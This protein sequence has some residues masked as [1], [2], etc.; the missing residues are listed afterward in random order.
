MPQKLGCRPR[1]G[2][3]NVRIPV[4]LQGRQQV[5]PK[6]HV[7]G[8]QLV[9]VRQLIDSGAAEDEQVRDDPELGGEPQVRLGGDGHLVLDAGRGFQPLLQEGLDAGLQQAL[10][11]QAVELP[12]QIPQ[13]NRAVARRLVQDPQRLTLGARGNQQM[14]VQRAVGDQPLAAGGGPDDLFGEMVDQPGGPAIGRRK[15]PERRPGDQSQRQGRRRQAAE[16]VNS[17]FPAPF[18]GCGAIHREQ[19]PRRGQHAIQRGA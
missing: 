11:T 2:R 3:R 12:R 10:Q 13:V 15:I 8:P 16:A 17:P 14:V 7:G 6:G 18:R 19:E 4:T 5:I 9:G 1:P